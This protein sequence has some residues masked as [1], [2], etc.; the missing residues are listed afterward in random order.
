[1]GKVVN[2]Y[3]N[4]RDDKHVMPLGVVMDERIADGYEFSRVFVDMRKYLKNPRLLEKRRQDEIKERQDN[5]A[6]K[7]VAPI[8]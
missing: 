8:D 3:R 6:S 1:M 5:K 7:E 2:D 4:N